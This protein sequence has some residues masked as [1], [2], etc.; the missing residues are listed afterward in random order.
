MSE[1]MWAK[2]ALQATKHFNK[3]FLSL[4]LFFTLGNAT[5]FAQ[6]QQVRLSSKTLTVQK[7]MSEIERITYLFG[8]SSYYKPFSLANC[9]RKRS[10]LP[11]CCAKETIRWM[12]KSTSL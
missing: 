6:Q 9:S 12:F 2:C 3:P 8:V 1:P 4:F 7:M 5:V 11:F 10:S